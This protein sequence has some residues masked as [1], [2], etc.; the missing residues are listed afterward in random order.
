MDYRSANERD[1]LQEHHETTI[2]AAGEGSSDEESDDSEFDL[3]KTFLENEGEYAE[4][5]KQTLVGKDY[6]LFSF[7]CIGSNPFLH[8]EP[9]AEVELL[10]RLLE[11]R[12]ELANDVQTFEFPTYREIEEMANDAKASN[13]RAATLIDSWMAEYSQV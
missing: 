7:Q 8:S 4:K 12:V 3:W 9:A 5:L 13:A 11:C 1:D 2:P 6:E 10:K